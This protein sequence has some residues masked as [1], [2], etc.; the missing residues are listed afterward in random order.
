MQHVD[1]TV[2]RVQLHEQEQRL[3]RLVG[4]PSRDSRTKSKNQLGDILARLDQAM[5][6]EGN[7][8][9]AQ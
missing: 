4:N 5:S 2:V 6:P 7:H 3:R 1:P 9:Q 8:G